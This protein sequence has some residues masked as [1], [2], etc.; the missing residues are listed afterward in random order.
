MGKSLNENFIINLF[1]RLSSDLHH[2]LVED[3]YDDTNIREKILEEASRFLVKM[4]WPSYGT[5]DENQEGMKAKMKI[6]IKC[7]HP[8]NPIEMT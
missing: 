2:E 7:M 6:A 8:F 1:G 4:D 5:D 3:S